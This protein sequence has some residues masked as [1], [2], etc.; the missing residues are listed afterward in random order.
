MACEL[1]FANL[2]CRL[3]SED[4]DA[5]VLFMTSGSEPDLHKILILELTGA[6]II[7]HGRVEEGTIEYMDV[8]VGRYPRL[9]DVPKYWSGVYLR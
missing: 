4:V 9:M 3:V 1:N 7:D 2:R 8:R 6:Y 5:Q